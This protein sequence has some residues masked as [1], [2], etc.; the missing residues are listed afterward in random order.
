VS[1]TPLIKPR[2]RK[3]APPALRKLTDPEIWDIYIKAWGATPV[4]FARAVLNAAMPK[5]EK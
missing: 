4:Q 3:P 5:D 1:T 2:A